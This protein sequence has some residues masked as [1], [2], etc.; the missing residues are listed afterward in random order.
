MVD[1]DES[2][3]LLLIVYLLAKKTGRIRARLNT[4]EQTNIKK[5]GVSKNERSRKRGRERGRI[6]EKHSFLSY[7]IAGK[8]MSTVEA[9]S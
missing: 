7:K 2:W 5:D 8:K 9:E 1:V 3:S 6:E 4:V